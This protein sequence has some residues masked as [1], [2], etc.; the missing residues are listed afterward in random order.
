MGVLENDDLENND[1]E[2]VDL[3]NED[4]ENDNR[5]GVKLEGLRGVRR[6]QKEDIREQYEG[7][8]NE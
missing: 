8:I 6:I 5:D 4:L 7:I 1:L 2:N 3:E